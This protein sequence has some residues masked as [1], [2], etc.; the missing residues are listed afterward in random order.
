MEAKNIFL[1]QDTEEFMRGELDNVT[2]AEGRVSLDV[3]QGGHVPYGCYTSP[4]VPMPLFDAVRVSWNGG[5]PQGTALEAQARVLVDGNWTAWSSFGRWS[6]YL[7]REGAKPAVRG[8]LV[9]QHDQLLLDSKVGSQ[10]QLR[11]YL[12]SKDE[13]LTPTVSP[14]GVSVRPV[15]VIPAGGRPAL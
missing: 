13:K 12:Y 7:P 6:P 1:L 5:A 14:L 3:V 15:D 8:P 2:V 10:V 9:L 11:I 4:A